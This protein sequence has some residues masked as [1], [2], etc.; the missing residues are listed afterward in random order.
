MWIPICDPKSL[1]SFTQRVSLHK[2]LQHR[3]LDENKNLQSFSRINQNLKRFDSF[4]TIVLTKLPNTPMQSDN[5]TWI[6]I[7][8]ASFMQ[9]VAFKPWGTQCRRWPQPCIR[10]E[11]S[12]STSKQEAE[13]FC[14]VPPTTDRRRKFVQLWSMRRRS[15]PLK[16]PCP[17]SMWSSCHP[18]LRNP[19]AKTQHNPNSQTTYSYKYCQEQSQTTRHGGLKDL[20]RSPKPHAPPQAEYSSTAMVSLETIPDGI[21]VEDHPRTDSSRKFPCI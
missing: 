3:Q 6:K 21:G 10:P 17:S 4:N 15:P 11:C 5:S 12:S 9:V 19:S 14:K 1:S 13:A 7:L 18:N 2:L 8:I 20:P 16:N